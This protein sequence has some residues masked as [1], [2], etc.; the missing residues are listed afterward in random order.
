MQIQSGYLQQICRG[1]RD[2]DPVLV[3]V[4]DGHVD[5]GDLCEREEEES[6]PAAGRRV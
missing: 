2:A 3:G 6:Q 4:R 1:H 5:D